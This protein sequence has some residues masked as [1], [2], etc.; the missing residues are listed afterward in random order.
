MAP[1]NSMAP[2]IPHRCKDRDGWEWPVATSDGPADWNLCHCLRDV[3][4]R[5]LTAAGGG[6]QRALH[7]PRKGPQR[8]GPGR[9][10]QT[11][12]D[13]CHRNADAR[14]VLSYQRRRQDF[15]AE[16]VLFPALAIGA[17]TK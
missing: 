16:I 7:R 17:S 3:A 15:A 12:A 10:P 13:T 1:G 14:C 5:L 6:K 11:S 2:F 4:R 9:T 8:L